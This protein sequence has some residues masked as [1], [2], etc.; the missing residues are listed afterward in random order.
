MHKLITGAVKMVV[1][2]VMAFG[3][4][5]MFTPS[6]SA[7]TACQFIHDDEGNLVLEQGA[8]QA[9]IDFVNGGGQ[10][11]GCQF[12]QTEN[13]TVVQGDG[14]VV[15]TSLEPCQIVDYEDD[16]I[17]DVAQG[18]C[19]A[20][21]QPTEVP[22]TEVPPTEVPPT[23]VPP[24]EVPPTE[25]PPTEVPPTEV[26]PTTVPTQTATATATSTATSTATVT[27]TV[28][29]THEPTKAPT[30][31]PADVSVLPSTG[32]GPTDGNSNSSTML[33]LGLMGTVLTIG[34]VAL[35]QRR[36]N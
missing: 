1:V 18:N 27:A 22:P 9:C 33:L 36:N 16:G 31:A 23:E 19:A 24:T 32:Q 25:V 3:L 14:C 5:S 7:L 29:P 12:V 10:Q 26:P 28:D 20:L 2:L 21:I 6:A 13:G 17:F 35:R 11:G 4:A 30:K 8:T 15:Q 34:A